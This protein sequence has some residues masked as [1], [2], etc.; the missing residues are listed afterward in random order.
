MLLKRFNMPESAV[1]YENQ[2]IKTVDNVAHTL[3][4]IDAKQLPISEF[5]TVS[6][7][8]YLDRISKIMDKFSLKSQ[9]I[10]AES[11]LRQRCQAHA[12]KMR[13]VDTEHGL[14]RRAVEQNYL[15]RLNRYD[16][17]IEKVKL[18]EDSMITNLRYEKKWQDEMSNWGYWGPLAL[19]V[20][21][22]SFTDLF[23]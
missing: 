10:A 15:R 18:T 16:R 13:L 12:G 21:N 11:A 23:F 20:R 22:D 6:T 7:G 2:S 17:A 19:A 3:N 1:L 4:L 8:Y 9:P 14:D 5:V